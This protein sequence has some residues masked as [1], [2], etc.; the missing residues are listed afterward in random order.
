MC[1]DHGLCSSCGGGPVKD[2][3]MTHAS[4]PP[5]SAPSEQVDRFNAMYDAGAPPW[6]IGRPQPAFLEL[7][8]G[9]LLTGR[10][11]DV[12]CGTGEHALMAAARRLDAT[13]I[14]AVPRAISI[15]QRKAQDRGLTARFVVW[16]AL[17]LPDLG[18]QFDTVLDSGLFHVFDDEDRLRFVAG[19]TAVIPSGGRYYM[20]C[21]SD[22]QPGTLGPRRIKQSEIRE[23]FGP[24]DW[25]VEA[26]DAVMMD[27]NMD[28]IG[29]YAW[30]ASIVRR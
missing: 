5:D 13:G 21:F 7:A 6:D 8:E 3:R 29:V 19:L 25:L 9:D 30:R 17:R 11:L 24:A 10:V 12:G 15:A 14:D 26:I 23:A 18:E 27:T 28:D 2:S 20:L 1:D 22:R 16:D 4:K